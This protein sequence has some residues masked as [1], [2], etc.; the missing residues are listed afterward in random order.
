MHKSTRLI[1]KEK[2]EENDSKGKEKKEENS[3]N[4]TITKVFVLIVSTASS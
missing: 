2:G 3:P 4:K 1:G